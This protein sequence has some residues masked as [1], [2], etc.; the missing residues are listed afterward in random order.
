MKTYTS[1]ALREMYLN[2]FRDRGHKG[3]PSASLIPE[4][5]PTVLFTTAGM[6]PLVPYLLGERHP[7][8]KRLTDVQKCVRTN[9]IDIIGTT[10][11]HLSFFEML[12]NF[13]FGKYFKKE[14]CA[15][16]L[17]FSTDVL[18]LPIEKLY[19]TVFKDDDENYYIEVN[20]KEYISEITLSERV[21]DDMCCR[22]KIG[23]AYYYFG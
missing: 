7:A 1:S 11:R 22:V 5:D 8:G 10:G 6:H 18:E 21:P 19:F 14:M 15:W 12:G 3:I 16:A 2:F 13:S 20:G 4:N 9:D 23:R 17:E